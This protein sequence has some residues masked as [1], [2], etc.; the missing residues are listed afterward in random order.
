LKRILFALFILLLVIGLGVLCYKNNYR[1]YSDV[2]A[3]IDAKNDLI[4]SKN[5]NITLKEELDANS[6]KLIKDYKAISDISSIT[7]LLDESNSVESIDS[8]CSVDITG[9]TITSLDKVVDLTKSVKEGSG[10]EIKLTVND[11]GSFL[12]WLDSNY[13][14]VDSMDIIYSSNSIILHVYNLSHEQ[15]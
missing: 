12:K 9:Y 3:Y 14:A 1:P 8:I 10:W 2:I 15:R 4:S 6:L 7:S 5:S 13:L 11:I